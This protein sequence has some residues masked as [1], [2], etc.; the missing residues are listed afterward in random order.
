MPMLVGGSRPLVQ[1][2]FLVKEKEIFFFFVYLFQQTLEGSTSQNLHQSRVVGS[3][4]DA[5][6]GIHL[7]KVMTN[8]CGNAVARVYCNLFF[9]DPTVI[10]FRF[11][12]KTV[13]CQC[14]KTIL[15]CFALEHSAFKTKQD[16][17]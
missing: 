2:C 1:G 7:F 9:Q 6:L 15:N 11:S 3:K 4:P 5:A 16:I 10:K 17:A 13:V 14:L 12:S 8:I